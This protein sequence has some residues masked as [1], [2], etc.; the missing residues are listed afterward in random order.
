[1]KME[2]KLGPNHFYHRLNELYIFEIGIGPASL[3]KNYCESPH[4]VAINLDYYTTKLK[5]AS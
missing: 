3:Q 4:N 1:M 5:E 2:E